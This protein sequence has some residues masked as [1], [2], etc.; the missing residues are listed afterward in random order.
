M[1]KMGVIGSAGENVQEA[2]AV[3]REIGRY[4]AE[5]ECAV[6]TGG[7]DG[8]P[9]EAALGAKEQGGTTLGISP[10]R[11]I[12]EHQR[13]YELPV[14][15]YDFLIFTGMGLKG[16][17]VI[18]VNTADAVIAISGRIGTLNELT[19]AYD[20]GRPIG[21][22]D[23]PGLGIEFPELA[24]KSGKSGPEIIVGKDPKKVVDGL[25]EI[26]SK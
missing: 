7:C 1:Y 23:S 14:E 12:Q 21:I 25:L 18:N 4:I 9:Y 11:D 24:R 16:R 13:I 6:V 3:A 2:S 20:H 22:L 26:L 17:N 19:I 10:A 5:R 15:G 8:L